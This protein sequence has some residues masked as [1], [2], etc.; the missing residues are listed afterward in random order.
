MFYA[1]VC[2]QNTK[3]VFSYFFE[4]SRIASAPPPS[5]PLVYPITDSA[6]KHNNGYKIKYNVL[7][8]GDKFNILVFTN[9][10]CLFYVL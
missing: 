8:N 6:P 5:V 2:S 7:S 3:T 4:N 1:I 9:I 10:K